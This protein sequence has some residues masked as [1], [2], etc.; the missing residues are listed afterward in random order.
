MPHICP[1]VLGTLPHIGGVISKGAPTVKISGLPAARV[2]DNCMCMGVAGVGAHSSAIVR[3]SSTVMICK[4]PA[5]FMGSNTATGG[6]I[7]AGVPNVQ[8]GM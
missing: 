4:Q 2:G 5:A 1:I 6:M 7:L 3:G 8:I